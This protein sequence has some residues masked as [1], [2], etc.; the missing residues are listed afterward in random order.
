MLRFNQTVVYLDL[1]SSIG[2]CPNRFG[3]D[4]CS[5]LGKVFQQGNCLIQTLKLQNTSLSN[6]D[7]QRIVDG[8]TQSNFKY[9]HTLDV[10]NNRIIG[11]I[12]GQLIAQL[13]T[14]NIEK[15]Q[16]YNL[17][18]LNISRNKIETNAAGIIF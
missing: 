5:A 11:T 6:E 1:G 4:W 7:F 14:R 15:D 10:S 17:H 8:I 16:G 12:A 18:T 2:S 9:L 13:L 3:N